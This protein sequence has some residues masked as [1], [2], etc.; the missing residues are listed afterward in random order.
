MRPDF[1]PE[2]L[3]PWVKRSHDAWVALKQLKARERRLMSNMGGSK[4]TSVG[5]KKKREESFREG[6]RKGYPQVASAAF[7]TATASTELKAVEPEVPEGLPVGLPKM[8][9]CREGQIQVS[10]L[11]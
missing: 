10:D 9:V 1:C 5:R 6:A 3:F 2:S 8:S 11:I 4:E 7:E